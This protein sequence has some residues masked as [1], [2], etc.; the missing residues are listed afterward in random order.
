[1]LPI[2]KKDLLL[3]GNQ[4]IFKVENVPLHQFNSKSMPLQ[5]DIFWAFLIFGTM[6]IMVS[7]RIFDKR[8]NYI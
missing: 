1:M 6:S 2:M 3:I 8:A 4:R 5:G 7:W